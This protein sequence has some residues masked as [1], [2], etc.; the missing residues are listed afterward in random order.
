MVRPFGPQWKFWSNILGTGTATHA[1]PCTVFLFAANKMAAV[2]E[3]LEYL[4]EKTFNTGLSEGNEG[5]LPNYYPVG[6]HWHPQAIT[7]LL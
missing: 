1:V 4:L 3:P 7:Q 2:H 5:I 6:D